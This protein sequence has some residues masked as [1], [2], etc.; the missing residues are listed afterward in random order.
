MKVKLFSLPC[1]IVISGI[2]SAFVSSGHAPLAAMEKTMNVDEIT[3]GMKGYGKTVFSGDR[4][5]LFNVEVLGILKNWE[6]KSNMILIKVSGGPLEKTGVIA[7]MSGS[8]IYINN[9]LIGALAYGWTF[10]KEAIAGVVPIH[11]MRNTLLN[12]EDKG[13]IP[14]TSFEWE[15]PAP[16]DGNNEKS[17]QEASVIQDGH[18]AMRPYDLSQMNDIK[19]TPIQSPLVVTGINNRVLQEMQPFF[20]NHGLY[21]VQGGSYGFQTNRSANTKLVPGASVAAILIKGDLNAAVV[22]TVTCA[23][24]ENIL[25]FGHPFLHTGIAD[26]PMATAYV[27]TILSS[28][29]NSVKMASPVNIVGRIN[30]DR[31]AGIAGVVGEHS[32][33]IPCHIEVEGSQKTA[34]DFEIVNDKALIPNLVLMAAQSAVLS[35]ERKQGEKSVQI[36]LT[37]HLREYERPV[38]AENVFYEL[39]QS[40]IPL[41]YM[42]Q[43]LQMMTNNPF[44][45]VQLDKIDLKIRVLD[46]RKTAHI[47]AIRVDKKHVKPGD[48]LQVSICLKPFTEEYVYQTVTAQIPEDTLPG[49]ILNITACDA[50]YSQALNMG[51]SAGKYLPAN[52]DQLVHYIETMEQNNNLVVR[53]SL[54]KRGLTYK[55][56]GFPSLPPSMLSIMN[57]SNQSGVG[58]LL[59]ELILRVPTPFILTGNQ[60][61]PISVK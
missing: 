15:L 48:N 9:R 5:S 55:G 47:E 49:S 37:A 30:Q 38:V 35:T 14:P 18:T 31:R 58:P 25:A 59:D 2:F 51:R 40:W 21:P 12:P 44:Q 43:P 60:S 36:K 23:E 8:P 33:M 39:G 56:E 50:M 26:L 6:A 28:Q 29:S 17:L 10:T 4:I 27:Y 53:I 34:Y 1:V 41:L 20:T 13:Y 24:G 46:V 22:G 54:P 45:K 57:F 7:G 42:V 11:E 61:V 32:H 16:F 3:A 52:L 19:L